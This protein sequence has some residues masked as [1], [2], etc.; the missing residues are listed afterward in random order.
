MI[1]YQLTCAAAH[2]FDGWFRSSA[3]FD[4]QAERGLL[5]CPAC[6]SA[7][8]RKALMAPALATASD[9]P[10][11]ALA[12]PSPAEPVTLVSE[13]DRA[14]RAMLREL[15]EHVTR[16][17]EDVGDR[18]P[19]VARQI[20]AEEIEPRSVYGRATFEEAKALAEEGVPVHPLPRFPDDGN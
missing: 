20:H 2:G 17:A 12:A 10:G 1:R 4:G 9:V 13:K 11:P 5:S 19:E 15:R 7:E 6:G 18:F 16:T 3:D 14:L 8:V